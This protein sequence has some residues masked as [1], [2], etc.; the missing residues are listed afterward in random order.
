MSERLGGIS[1]PKKEYTPEEKRL[2]DAVIAAMD[3]HFGDKLT[4]ISK[5]ATFEA[6]L[7]QGVYGLHI[8]GYKD[9][10]TRIEHFA[11]RSADLRGIKPEQAA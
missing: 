8:S 5:I 10:I 7:R 4:E 1:N 3:Q 11:K 9:A 6:I 2:V